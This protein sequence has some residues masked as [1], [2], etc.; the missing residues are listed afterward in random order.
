MRPR[1]R[2]DVIGL[3]AVIDAASGASCILY[4]PPGTGK[5]TVARLLSTPGRPLVALNA[6]QA[7]VAVIRKA[8]STSC[9]LFIDEIH[10]LSRTQQ[11]ALLPI[12]ESGDVCLVGA[13][14]EN[15]RAVI[16]PALV[17][18]VRLIRLEPIGDDTMRAILARAMRDGLDGATAEPGA[19]DAIIARAQGDARKA[20]SILDGACDN[21]VVSLDAVKRQD[22][23]VTDGTADEHY[24]LVSAFIKS[25]RASDPDA[26][27]HW[28]ARLLDAGE[29]PMYVARRIAI[30]ASEDVGLADPMAMLQA[31]A[32]MESTARIG[33]PECRIPL[34]QAALAVATA[35]KSDSVI[36]GITKASEDVRRG[37]TGPVPVALRD[38]HRA[39]NRA[40]GNGEEYVYPHDLPGHIADQQCLPNA[41]KDRRYYHPVGWGAEKAVSDRMERVRAIKRRLHERGGET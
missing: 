35:P 24:D 40:E 14:T 27:L 15:P 36:R 2:A 28:L 6:S 25:M 16:E 26:T 18:R 1:T 30:H 7:T 13:T 38:A 33:M 3:E 41:A 10:R 21:G 39:S 32:A 20:L 8:A 37:L 29:D 5:T 4:G 11:D 22:A 9:T 23:S 19:V 31:T 17:S 12:T 34:A